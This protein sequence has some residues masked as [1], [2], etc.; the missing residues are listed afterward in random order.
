VAGVLRGSIEARPQP[1]EGVT[2]CRLL[3]KEDGRLDWHAAAAYLARQ[4]RAYD[5][6]PGTF[7]TWDGRRLKVLVAAPLPAGGPAG[8]DAPGQVRRVAEVVPAAL[9]GNHRLAVQ[10]GEGRLEL[11]RL[12]LEGKPALAPDALLRGYPALARAQLT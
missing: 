2:I 12:Q 3:R 9:D 11:L 10:C 8:A 4:V 7:T 6:W 1:T 5:P